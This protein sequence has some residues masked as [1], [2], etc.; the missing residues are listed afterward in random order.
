MEHASVMLNEA[1]TALRV[2]RGG[3]YIDG[4]YGRGGHSRAIA[5]SGGEVL[6][7]DRDDEAVASGADAGERIKVAKARHGD[8]AQTARAYGWDVADGVLL[9]LGVSSPQL[10]NA[11][12]GFSFMRDGP[13]DMRMDNKAGE[14]AADIVNTRCERELTEIFRTLGEEPQAG[15][16]ARAIVRERG[17]RPFS[18]TLQLASFVERVAGRHSPRHPATR[19]F[20]ALRMAVNDEPGE[21]RRALEGAAE[22][23]RRPGGRLAVITFE[24]ITDRI[25]KQFMATHA[26]RE[27]SLQEGGSRW[28]GTPPRMRRVNTRAM[29]PSPGEVAANPRA[30]SA[31]LRVAEMAEEEK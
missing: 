16:I 24:S 11:A 29:R 22:I 19:I 6:G 9:D 27:V 7:L 12:R 28:E 23:L 2:K 31:K 14:T 1:V 13:L 26:G 20:Q 18:G 15:K 17:P 10:D 30:R 3:R 5:L 25:V 4:T 21:L 8:L